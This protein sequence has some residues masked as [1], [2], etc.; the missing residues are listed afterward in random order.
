M[1]PLDLDLIN[2]LE[3]IAYSVLLKRNTIELGLESKVPVF[4]KAFFYQRND[5]SFVRDHP[6]DNSLFLL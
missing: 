4:L 5:C 6:S 3:L 2:R 1:N